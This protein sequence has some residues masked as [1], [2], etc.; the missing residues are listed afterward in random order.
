M[1]DFN[2]DTETFKRGTDAKHFDKRRF[3]GRSFE[4]RDGERGNFNKRGGSKREF[5]KKPFGK[6]FNKNGHTPTEEHSDKVNYL[7]GMHPV[8]EALNSEKKIDKVFFKKG[9]RVINFIH[10]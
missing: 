9:M 7:F 4:K 3:G 1:T 8:I 2:N 10:C 6:P 5:D